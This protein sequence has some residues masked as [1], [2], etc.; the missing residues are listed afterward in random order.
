M[1]LV[2]SL[3]AFSVL[4]TDAEMYFSSDK[5]GQNRVTNVQ[6]GDEIFIV[7]YDPDQNID[8]DIRDK[9]TGDTKIMDP[10]TGA[11]IVWTVDPDFDS[12]APTGDYFEETGAD[13]GLFVSQRA[14]QIGT[15][16]SF[17]DG[18]KWLF[19][20]VVDLPT[21]AGVVDDFQWGHWLYV[22]DVSD[23][24]AYA[25]EREWLEA[26]PTF[27]QMQDPPGLGAPADR[28]SNWNASQTALDYII[29]RFEN[30]DT[31]VGMFQDPNDAT[32]VAV[33]MMKII[34]TEATIAWDETIYKD[35]NTSATITVVDADENLNCNEVEYVPV[36]II[37]NP[38][39]WN[40]IPAG[41]YSPNSFCLLKRTG[42]VYGAGVSRDAGAGRRLSDSLV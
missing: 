35:A 3:F 25:D 22:G 16:E 27:H 19:T 9:F 24:D 28:P 12:A 41:S 7:I 34:D 26:G 33:A 10:K 15:R 13:T 38:G 1:L 30:M 20:H 40:P 32:D 5:N 18:S 8:C 4:A 6:E 29:G 14:F 42:G 23:P 31:L 11:Y 39:S 2:T 17:A 21:T 36:F 37:V